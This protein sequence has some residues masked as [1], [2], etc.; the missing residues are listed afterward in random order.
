MALIIINNATQQNRVLWWVL[1]HL[2][3]W[4]LEEVRRMPFHRQMLSNKKPCDVLLMPVDLLPLLKPVCHLLVLINR[5]SGLIC[6]PWLDQCVV[7]LCILC[8]SYQLFWRGQLRGG[9][10]KGNGVWECCQNVFI[11]PSQWISAHSHPQEL[12]CLW[13]VWRFLWSA[14]G[15]ALNRENCVGCKL[16]KQG[17]LVISHQGAEDPQPTQIKY[18]WLCSD[19]W[20]A[21]YPFHK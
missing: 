8:Y 20:K 3:P 7:I 21:G 11:H 5:I 18:I 4:S 1:G 12:L 13:A 9:S 14:M 2:K 15:T 17:E 10:G 16:P 19:S 6:V